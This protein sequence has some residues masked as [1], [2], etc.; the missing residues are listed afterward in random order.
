MLG[1]ESLKREWAL[2]CK[3]SLTTVGYCIKPMW[4]KITEQIARWSVVALYGLAFLR[5]LHW[6]LALQTPMFCAY[7]GLMCIRYVW[8]PRTVLESMVLEPWLLSLRFC[9][10]LEAVLL[11][12]GSRSSERRWLVAVMLLSG[13]VGVLVLTYHRYLFGPTPA[14]LYRAARQ[15]IHL[16]LAF[17]AAMGLHCCWIEGFQARTLGW[18][19]KHYLILM[20]HLMLLA[21]CGFINPAPIQRDLYREV[22]IGYFVGSSACLVMWLRQARRPAILI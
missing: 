10:L 13:G 15:H 11:C 16:G 20:C 21:G 19:G 12:V 3:R 1:D 14:D 5:Q 4:L 22:R 17:A 7:L 18:A 8:D 9:C 6:R 2:R